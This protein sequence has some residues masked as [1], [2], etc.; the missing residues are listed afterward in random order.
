MSS[1]EIPDDFMKKIMNVLDEDEK[2]KAAEYL[3]KLRD[4][5]NNEEDFEDTEE[6][7]YKFEKNEDIKENLR[8]KNKS[9]FRD[10][11]L[12]SKKDKEC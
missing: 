6:S 7:D 10:A 1:D 3:K 12:K 4:A 5:F 9:A 8:N 2:K 11:M